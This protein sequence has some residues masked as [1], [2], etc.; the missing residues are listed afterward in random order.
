VMC[1]LHLFPVHGPVGLDLLPATSPWQIGLSVFLFRLAG[2]KIAVSEIH[3]PPEPLG[4][5]IKGGCG[6]GHQ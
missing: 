2:I 3:F 1:E 5:Q 6:A 4:R